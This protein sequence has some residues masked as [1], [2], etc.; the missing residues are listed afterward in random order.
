VQ[1]IQIPAERVSSFEKV[2]RGI[3]GGAGA[4]A[5]MT[6]RLL[7]AAWVATRLILLAGVVLAHQYC[8]PEFYRYAGLLAAGKLP[9]RNFTVEYPPVAVVLLLLPAIPLLPFARVAPRPDPAFAPG[10]T[11]L[12]A[13]DPTR[14]GAYGLSFA[15][16]MLLIDLL[17]V[18]LVRTAARRWVASDPQGL[19]AGIL[20]VLLVFAS[21]A[22]LQKFDLVLGTLCLLGVVALL[23]RRPAVAWTALAL[24]TLVKGYPLLV[25]PIFAGVYLLQAR[26]ATLAQALRACMRPLLDGLLTFGA[27]LGVVTLA[28]VLYAGWAP[29]W[30]TITYHAQRGAE[31]ESL[32]ANV[33]LAAGWLPGLRPWTVFSPADLSRIVLGPLARWAGLGSVFLLGALML[34]SYGAAWR[35][36]Q[37]VGLRLYLHSKQQAAEVAQLALVATAAVLLAFELSFLA[38]PGHYLLVLIPF[39]ALIRLPSRRVQGVFMAA[40]VAVAVIGQVIAIPGVWNALRT[41]APGAVVL[42]SLRNMAWVLAYVTLIMALWRWVQLA[43]AA[44]E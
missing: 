21:G 5:R 22:L 26:R 15:C 11:H 24:A 8:D 4:S 29:V 40:L 12:P 19:Y 16:E 36:F 25:V 2:A 10:F 14:Y 20:Y 13:P 27:V 44:S 1:T 17:T 6:T 31:I 38:L 18:W 37:G 30:E 35:A 9:Y 7:A 23:E 43:R 3:V 34:A 39:A 28:V 32:Y 42:L 33:M 41:L